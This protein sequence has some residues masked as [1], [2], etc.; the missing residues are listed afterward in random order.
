MQKKKLT[1]IDLFSGAGGL[2]IGL[3]NAGF[4]IKLCV[5]NDDLVER[6]HKR[7]FPK[8]PMINK[9]VRKISPKDIQSYLNGGSVDV[10]I[11]GPPCQDFSSAADEAM[12]AIP[13]PANTD[14]ISSKVRVPF[15]ESWIFPA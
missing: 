4:D 14:T 15:P 10:I 7:N 2:H 8:I 5:D 1:A 6:T 12:T 13:L 11:G 9:D 3:E